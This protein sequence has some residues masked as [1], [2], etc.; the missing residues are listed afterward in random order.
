VRLI[1]TQDRASGVNTATDPDLGK[2]KEYTKLLP[3]V[4][5]RAHLTDDLFLR[6][7]YSKS[8]T[9]PDYSSLAPALTLVPANQ[10]GSEGNPGLQPYKAD[11]FD[12]ALEWYFAK[13]GSL[14]GTAF[15]K[16]VTGFPLTEASWVDIN[17]TQYLLSH[18]INSGSGKV[19]GAEV[20]YQQFFTFLPGWLSGFGAQANVTYIDSSVPTSVAGF[21]APLP[22][23][24]RWSYN[25]TGMYQKGP[26]SARVAWNWRSNFLAGIGPASGVGVVP[27]MSQAYGQLDAAINYDINK[28]VTLSLEGANLTQT[29][30][31]YYI[32]TAMSP[33][34]TFQ[35]DT[36]ILAGVHFKW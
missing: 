28:H 4:N 11:N 17:G 15:Y 19:E 34:Q 33:A 3:S 29:K 26:L 25:M 5:L 30:R 2:T 20:G 31:S 36:Q 21:T 27:T 8:L 7:A 6:F 10:T 13:G 22:N 16:N 24:S 18:P 35:D 12:V 1:D 32:Q 9:R 14:Y 23:M